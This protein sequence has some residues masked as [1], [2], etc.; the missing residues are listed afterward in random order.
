M[1][2]KIFILYKDNLLYTIKK[3]LYNSNREYYKK[4]IKKKQSKF[5]KKY[6]SLKITNKNIEEG[7]AT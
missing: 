6:K 5:S 4:K 3:T 1:E 7:R 2:Y